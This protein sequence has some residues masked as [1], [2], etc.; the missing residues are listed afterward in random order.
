MTIAASGGIAL[1]YQWQYSADSGTTWNSVV[2]GTPSNATYSGA[3]S[4]SFSVSGINAI[5]TLGTYPYRCVVSSTGSGC[6]PTTSNPV[7]VKVQQIPTAG[8]IGADQLICY[9]TTPGK[10]TSTTDGTGSGSVPANGGTLY[11][12][13][14]KSTDDGAN[15]SIISGA[16]LKEYQPAALRT[17]T[18]YRRM[19]IS[20]IGSNVCNS[21]YTPTVKITVRPEFKPGTITS[22]TV[23][24]CTSVD[25]NGQNSALPTGGDGTFS[26]QWKAYTYVRYNSQSLSDVT[27]ATSSNYTATSVA[28]NNV[29]IY[30]RNAKDGSCSSGYSSGSITAYVPNI[31]I[32]NEQY[33]GSQRPSIC[34]GG[35]YKITTVHLGDIGKYTYSYQWEKSTDNNNWTTIT[36][37]ANGSSYTA[38][39]EINAATRYY[40]CKATV[41]GGTQGCSG[42]I[43]YSDVLTLETKGDPTLATLTLAEGEICKGGSSLLQA[44]I[45]GG[46]IYSYKV[47]WEIKSSTD[48]GTTYTS[49]EPKYEVFN[50]G[51]SISFDVANWDLTPATYQINYALIKQEY[52]DGCDC[53]KG[54]TSNVVILKV[55]PDPTLTD[56]TESTSLCQGG[57]TTLT[58][59][60]DLLGGT[61]AYSLNWQYFKPDKTTTETFPVLKKTYSNSGYQNDGTIQTFIV[62]PKVTSITVNA[63]GCTRSKYRFIYRRK[64]FLLQRNNNWS[65]RRTEAKDFSRATARS[66]KC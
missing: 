34:I 5:S 9:N 57:N 19:T 30:Y 24:G 11:Y 46:N 3:A 6:D 44:N 60:V 47:K 58:T 35:S 25:I 42:I 23:Y 36:T 39:A 55:A 31:F 43:T 26:Y 13:W 10:L 50:N 22:N 63:Y 53:E 41:T 7:N 8:S 66:I 27:L 62:P 45:S 2:N 12:Q 1:S 32:A 40:R 56:L 20:T 17:T 48:G 54:A 18:L 37:D 61:N 14:E 49:M 15:Y 4:T 38:Y 28:Q 64:R 29:T 65:N 33:S 16:T 52:P 21:S 51:S 59:N